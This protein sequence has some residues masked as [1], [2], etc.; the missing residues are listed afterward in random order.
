CQ[1]VYGNPFTF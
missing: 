1:Q